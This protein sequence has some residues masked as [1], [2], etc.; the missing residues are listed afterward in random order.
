[1]ICH[2]GDYVE[3]TLKNPA[4][5]IFEHNI[6]FHASTGAL[7][8]GGLTLISPGEQVKLR[9]KATKAGTYIY[10]CA[11]GGTMIPFHVVSGMNGAV[12]V[13]RGT[14]SRT[15]TATRSAMT[16]PTTS[17]ST[18]STCRVMPMA[19]SSTTP[20]TPRACPTCST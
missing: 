19:T 12:M 9:W 3:L 13:L 1:M 10:H 18:T 16:G 20:T 14:D 2:E 8:G 5:N 11:P 15:V 6:D 17:A 4:S 7:G